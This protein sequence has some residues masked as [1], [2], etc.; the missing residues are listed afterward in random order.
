ML[1][2]ITGKLKGEVPIDLMITNAKVFNVFTMEFMEVDVLIDKGMIIGFG[3]ANAKEIINATGKYLIPGLIDSHMHI[4]STMLSPIEYSKVA[5][6]NGVTTVFAD[7]HEVAN[8]LGTDGIDFMLCEVERALMDINVMLPSSVPCSMISNGN[9]EINA[10]DL[11]PYYSHPFVYG[12]AEVMD[13]S[14]VEATDKDYVQKIKDSKRRNLTVDGHMA[15][16]QPGEV[17]LLRVY[18]VSTDHECET[19]QDLIDR[20]SRGVNVHIREGSA[21]KNFT[22]L[23]SAVN[24]SNNGMISFCTDDVSIVDLIEKGSINHIIRKGISEGYAPELLIKM[25]T[26]NAARAYNLT[27]KGAIAPGHVADLLILDDIESFTINK[28][29]KDGLEMNSQLDFTTLQEQVEN[30]N[31]FD[32]VS[33]VVDEDE[34]D[35]RPKHNLAID[36][37]N[38][39]LVTGK[40]IVSAKEATHLSKIVVINRYGKDDY[41]VSYVKGFDLED[42][43]I[44]STISHDYHNLVLIGRNDDEIR[45]M[46][47]FIK[48]TQGGIYT[49]F[50]DKFNHCKLEIAGLMSN[51]TINDTYI[52]FKSLLKQTEFLG[53]S[54]P[55][56]A[57]SFLTLDVIPYLKITD[58]GLYD[59]ETHS[60]IE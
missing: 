8:A 40:E 31:V 2:N 5:L 37:K 14:R 12:L 27:D 16:L 17:D 35:L 43:V 18:G 10:S 55:F 41:F 38:G 34:I 26:I 19:K 23:M 49:L 7:C 59:F 42:G 52:S 33:I 53:V 44:A 36:V 60:L 32:A 1:I 58:K 28:V 46:I 13:Y 24:L 3:S 30:E 20:I 56:L 11:I 47:K 57:M 15:G 25:A 6:A 29:I 4:E 51:E 54:E 22:E 50:N 48:T 9:N 21:A 39:S 45:K